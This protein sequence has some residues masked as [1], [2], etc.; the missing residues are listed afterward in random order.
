MLTLHA[1]GGSEMMKAARAAAEQFAEPPTL[2]AVTALTSISETEAARIGI[3]GNIAGWVE[4]L[5]GLALESGI[6]GMVASPHEVAGLRSR[7]GTE[8]RLVIPGIRPAGASAQ[9]QARTST[10]A[11]AIRAGASY[12]V[13]GR[14]ILQAPAPAAAADAIVSEI[15]A[16]DTN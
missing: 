2:L 7:F 3:P 5:A 11:G 9:D 6:Q 13:V 1:S 8:P 15:A 12:L 16:A 14:P 4:T 10:P